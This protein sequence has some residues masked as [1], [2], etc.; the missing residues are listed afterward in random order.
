[1]DGGR[2]GRA[3]RSAAR[4][5]FWVR[6]YGPAE[7][8]CLVTMLA[9]SVVA[10]RLTTS[11][12]LL[13]ASAIAGS[14]V[15]F[16]GVLV[17]TVGREQRRVIKA[18]QPRYAARVASRTVLLL[19][20]EFGAAELLDTFVWR[21]LL[22]VSAVVLLDAPVWGLLAGKVAADVLF[23]AVSALGYRVTEL[24]GIRRPGPDEVPDSAT[25]RESV[26]HI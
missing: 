6:R 26:S 15:G 14:T 10:A 7:A 24:T 9:A 12:P 22:M 11:P 25:C 20:A 19:T 21:P 18:E 16:Y 3:Q 4:W 2:Q 5:W 13:A 1:V 8:A 23:Y 17:V